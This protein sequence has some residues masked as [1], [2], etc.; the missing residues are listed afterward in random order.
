VDDLVKQALQRWPNVPAIAGWLKLT[1]RGDWLLT[2]EVASGVRITHR[3]MRRFIDRNYAGGADGRWFFQNGPQKVYVEL[4]YTPWVFA[5]H[6]VE[7]GFSLLSHT[8]IATLPTSLYL[9]ENGHFL[10]DTPLGVG[11][12]LDTDMLV[13]STYLTQAADDV[14]QL[15]VDWRLPTPQ[16]LQHN[17]WM[18]D[19]QAEK[20]LATTPKTLLVQAVE[21]AQVSTQFGFA[22][23]PTV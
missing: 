15:Q 1:A 7:G 11:V 12:M 10:F 16:Q 9:D 21:R 3:N 17:E 2:G 22:D 14:W 13:L 5:L 18:L 4:E 6:P 8:R 20:A 23:H 19:A